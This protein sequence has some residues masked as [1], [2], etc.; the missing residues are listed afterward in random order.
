MPEGAFE[1][2]SFSTPGV[3]TSAC[4]YSFLRRYAE[5]AE[6]LVEE[7]STPSL[8][9]VL[10]LIKK[11]HHRA[12]LQPLPAMDGDGPWD[13]P[14]PF[15]DDNWIRLWKGLFQHLHSDYPTQ[16]ATN[17]YRN[18][19]GLFF[20]SSAPVSGITEWRTD[21]FHHQAYLPL[22][23]L[24]KPIEG[25]DKD[26]QLRIF[27][28]TKVLTLR[29]LD[30]ASLPESE[31]DRDETVGYEDI[32]TMT[33]PRSRAP[34]VM[35]LLDS[36]RLS[37]E[38]S[39]LFEVLESLKGF[40]SRISPI[41]SRFWDDV[42]LGTCTGDFN[43]T[44]V[45]SAVTV[46][47]VDESGTETEVDSSFSRLSKP[48]FNFQIQ[49]RRAHIGGKDFLALKIAISSKVILLGFTENRETA[50][51]PDKVKSSLGAIESLVFEDVFPASDALKIMQIFDDLKL[52]AGS[53]QRLTTALF[54]LRVL[55]NA[56][57]S[58]DAASVPFAT[59]AQSASA[60]PLT[61]DGLGAFDGGADGEAPAAA[62]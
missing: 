11:D 14:A 49:G 5:E 53:D 19:P 6:V 12:T 20:Q 51:V 47:S 59:V 10:E 56:D 31:A 42:V 40:L 61:D 15:Q 2:W 43:V 52:G 46:K 50:T 54:S 29:F 22:K 9:S 39:C 41:W 32:G 3:R 1:V 4:V 24:V 27:L 38:P 21:F 62:N 25:G 45:G 57:G 26:F 44:A 23:I 30:A 60:T 18:I 48:G 16:I 28:G 7:T 55:S 35:N 34:E 17:T 36:I 33:F 13:Y 58:V 8:K 37:A